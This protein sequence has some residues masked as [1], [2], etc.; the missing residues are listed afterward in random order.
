VAGGWYGLQNTIRSWA[1]RGSNRKLVVTF[2]PAKREASDAS[3]AAVGNPSA[4]EQVLGFGPFG[5]FLTA[6]SADGHRGENLIPEKMELQ[7]DWFRS[8]RN[9]SVDA[10][11]HLGE[12]S[13]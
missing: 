11:I 10:L 5:R 13:P 12:E 3:E 2:D 4:E 6:A 1:H 7:F 8:R 9:G